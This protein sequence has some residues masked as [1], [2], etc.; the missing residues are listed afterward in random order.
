MPGA[1]EGREVEAIHPP[2]EYMP[3]APAAPDSGPT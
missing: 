1:S 2:W 3:V